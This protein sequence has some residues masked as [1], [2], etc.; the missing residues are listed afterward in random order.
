MLCKWG[1]H[2][3]MHH[4]NVLLSSFEVLCMAGVAPDMMSL[5][6]KWMWYTLRL[7]LLLLSESEKKETG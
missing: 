3:Q 7:V 6:E 1:S 2:R 4:W 5:L